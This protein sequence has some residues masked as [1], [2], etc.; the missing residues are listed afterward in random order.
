MKKKTDLDK[1]KYSNPDLKMC[2]GQEHVFVIPGTSLEKGSNSFTAIME[3]FVSFCVK[4]SHFMRAFQFCF[5][6]ERR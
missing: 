6:S 3:C 2:L 4:F 1:K 5:N